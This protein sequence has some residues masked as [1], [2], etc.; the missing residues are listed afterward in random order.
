MLFELIL[1]R[2]S[3][4][5]RNIALQIVTKTRWTTQEGHYFIRARLDDFVTQ[6]TLVK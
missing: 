5:L 4:I 2:F 6:L 1:C 3:D